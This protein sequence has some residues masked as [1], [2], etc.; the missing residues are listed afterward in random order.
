MCCAIRVWNADLLV[1]QFVSFVNPPIRS[2]VLIFLLLFDLLK[3]LIDHFLLIDI[4]ERV[5]SL[6][7]FCVLRL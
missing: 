6:I 1:G 7:R 2:F 5:Q 4:S 3:L